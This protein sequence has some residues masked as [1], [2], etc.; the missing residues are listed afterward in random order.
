MSIE[1]NKAILRR[2]CDEMWNQRRFRELMPQLAG[3]LYIRHEPTGTVTVTVEE[4]IERCEKLVKE[5]NLR[6]KKYEL[7]AEGDKVACCGVMTINSDIVSGLQLYRLEN[8]KLV[9]TWYPG[10]AMGIEW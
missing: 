10:I 7:I 4:Y 8:R 1:E 6:I 5:T 9:E 2:W 3:P